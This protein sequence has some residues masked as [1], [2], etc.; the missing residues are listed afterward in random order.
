MFSDTRFESV[1]AGDTDLAPKVLELF[2][3]RAGFGE[4][5]RE[6][7]LARVQPRIKRR[8]QNLL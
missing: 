2:L 7:Q 4:L 8:D 1:P 5:F 3:H 6:T